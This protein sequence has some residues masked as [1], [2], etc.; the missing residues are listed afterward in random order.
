[1]LWVPA[2]KRNCGYVYKEVQYQPYSRVRAGALLHFIGGEEATK[3]SSAVIK[4]AVGIIRETAAFQGIL[5]LKILF[6]QVIV[7]EQAI[8]IA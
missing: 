1:M 3:E 2:N 8:P 5:Q 4:L 6:V 7:N